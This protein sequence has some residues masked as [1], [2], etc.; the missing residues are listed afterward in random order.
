MNQKRTKNL[1]IFFRIGLFALLLAS[2]GTA[3]ML[4]NKKSDKDLEIPVESFTHSQTLSVVLASGEKEFLDG[5]VHSLEE[6]DLEEAA[7][8]LIDSKVSWNEFPLMYDG[9]DLKKELSEGKGLVFTKAFTVFYGDFSDGKPQGQC[10]AFQVLNLEEGKRYD[11]S[12]GTWENGKMNGYGECGYSYYEGLYEDL[13]Q[14]MNRK[15]EKRGFFNNDLLDGEVQYSST[16][17]EGETSLW[18]F[19]VEKGEIAPD[20]RWSK[21]ERDSGEIYYRLLA[22]NETDHAYVLSE[23]GMGEERW[24]NLI[25]FER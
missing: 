23:S 14:G 25:L 15:D 5:L 20:E 7:K 8:L 21:E 13:S 18:R 9:T 17:K 2:L 19:Q 24:K 12:S 4:R 10:L 6:G 22:E 1:Q 16:N 3:G 11:Y